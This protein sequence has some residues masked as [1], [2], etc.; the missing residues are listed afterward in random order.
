MIR[1]DPLPPA[2]LPLPHPQEVGGKQTPNTT[3]HREAPWPSEKEGRERERGREGER[4]GEMKD[5][6]HFL[7]PETERGTSPCTFDNYTRDV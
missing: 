6:G 2:D 3:D 1:W 4:E 7:N 5:L